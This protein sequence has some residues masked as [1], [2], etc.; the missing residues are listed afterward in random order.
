MPKCQLFGTKFI[1]LY[2][3]CVYIYI[4]YIHTSICIY[5]YTQI[6]CHLMWL[7]SWI[8]NP[9]DPPTGPQACEVR[10]NGTLWLGIFAW[11][12]K[13]SHWN[14]MAAA[15]KTTCCRRTG[16]S[17]ALYGNLY[18]AFLGFSMFWRSVD[19][20]ARLVIRCDWSRKSNMV[21]LESKCNLKLTS[22]HKAT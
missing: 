20:I 10:V 6:Q 22:W 19:F 12:W 9:V 4:I 21:K 8:L 14:A 11:T 16:Q 2:T 3:V 15:C 5:I 7:S 17:E 1:R 18:V 13:W